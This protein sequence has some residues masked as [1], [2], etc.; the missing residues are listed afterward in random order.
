VTLETG[1]VGATGR[2]GS[3]ERRSPGDGGTGSFV[4]GTG[5]FRD[6]NDEGR[7]IRSPIENVAVGGYSDRM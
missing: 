5:P 3:Q 4:T 2:G 1:A 6:E 7:M